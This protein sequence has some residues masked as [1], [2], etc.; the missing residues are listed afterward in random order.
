MGNKLTHPDNPNAKEG[1]GAA[2]ITERN[3]TGNID[4]FK[5]LTA[6]RNIMNDFLTGQ[7]RSITSVIGNKEGARIAITIPQAMYTARNIGDREG[8]ATEEVQFDAL[9]QDMGCLLTIF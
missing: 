5:T 1:F 4:P 6:T 8:I 2:I 9:G 3:F 7:A